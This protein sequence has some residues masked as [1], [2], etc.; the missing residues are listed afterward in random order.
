MRVCVWLR[1]L[2]PFCADEVSLQPGRACAPI[3]AR[4]RHYRHPAKRVATRH[5]AKASVCARVRSH[6]EMMTDESHIGSDGIRARQTWLCRSVRTFG[7]ALLVRLREI[8]MKAPPFA[9]GGWR[10]TGT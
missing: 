2:K 6:G 5:G 3:A 10:A 9:R 8:L 7:G 1:C 4:L